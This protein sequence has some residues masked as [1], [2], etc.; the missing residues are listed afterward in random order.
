MS[1]RSRP[2]HV[3]A[4]QALDRYALP[5]GFVGTHRPGLQQ[6]TPE[7]PERQRNR[8]VAPPPY[9]RR[10]TAPATAHPDLAHIHPQPAQHSRQ[11]RPNTA[12]IRRYPALPTGSVG[13]RS[14][15]AHAATPQAHTAGCAR[16][17]RHDEI[18]TH[19]VL[20]QQRQTTHR[21]KHLHHNHIRQIRIPRKPEPRTGPI[22]D[23]PDRTCLHTAEPPGEHSNWTSLA[24]PGRH[25]TAH[26]TKHLHH[27][28]IR[29]LRTP[30]EPDQPLRTGSAGV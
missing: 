5:P 20:L 22:D 17:P 30:H 15:R 9:Y 13:R 23:R 16:T 18:R 4:Q 14:H 6:P 25:W 21:G 1:H 11:P 12:R 2:D 10:A 7:S 29:S 27:G 3:R 28:H 24:L 26:A 19:V 8:T